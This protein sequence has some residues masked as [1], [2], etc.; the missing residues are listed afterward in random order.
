MALIPIGIVIEHA[1]R[2][3]ETKV[4]ERLAGHVATKDENE[5]AWRNLLPKNVWL[6][7]DPQSGVFELRYWELPK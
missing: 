6:I 2:V 5:I 7:T 4:T 3:A 1:K